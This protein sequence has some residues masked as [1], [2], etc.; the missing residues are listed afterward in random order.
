MAK[1]LTTESLLTMGAI[2][3]AQNG[4]NCF[5]KY[6]TAQLQKSKIIVLL[7]DCAMAFRSSDGLPILFT[8][9]VVWTAISWQSGLI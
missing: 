7:Y 3:A 6:D 4:H 2:T 9:C 8:A 5:W 1:S